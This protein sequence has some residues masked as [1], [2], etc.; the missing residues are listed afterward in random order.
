MTASPEDYANAAKLDILEI[1]S[2]EKLGVFEYRRAE[3]VAKAMVLFLGSLGTPAEHGVIRVT[4]DM[5]EY[6]APHLHSVLLGRAFD[7]EELLE[8]KYAEM[9]SQHTQLRHAALHIQDA[10]SVIRRDRAE[11]E[12]HK[13]ALREHEKQLGIER[14]RLQLAADSANKNLSLPVLPQLTKPPEKHV[15]PDEGA[16]L[17]L[18]ERPAGYEDAIESYGSESDDPKDNEDG[19]VATPPHI[20][21]GGEPQ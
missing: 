10:Q 2:K 8:K 17:D 21:G 14:E 12:S 16:A 20:T 15:D 13:S 9:L 19:A 1:L 18:N 7:G 3:E 6:K 4:I 5:A 11:V